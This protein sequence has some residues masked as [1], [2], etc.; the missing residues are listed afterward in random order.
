MNNPG[1]DPLIWQRLKENWSHLQSAGSKLEIEFRLISDPGDEKNI[2]A[3]DVIQKI[4]A[5]VLTE[6]V[7]KNAGEAYAT[8]GI[9]GLAVEALT[10]AYK[11]QLR[12]LL[13][14]TDQ[15]ETDLVV[16]M[17]PTSTTSGEVRA[18]RG[19]E[20]SDVRHSLP[21]NYVHYYLLTALRE[22]MVDIVGDRW[23]SVKAVYRSG[24]LEFYFEY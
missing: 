22:K 1:L 14:Q 3:I 2:L 24:E 4:N 13:G 7:Q 16:T 23:N 19:Q 8:L 21:V 20:N 11:N 18:Y 10:Q 15:A 5:D 6:T 17:T 12:K 9:T